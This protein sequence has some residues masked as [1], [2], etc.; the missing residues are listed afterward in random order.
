MISDAIFELSYTLSTGTT[1]FYCSAEQVKFSLPTLRSFVLNISFGFPVK[2][3]FLSVFIMK[4]SVM[5][6]INKILG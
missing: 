6:K 1:L 5:E 4:I 3:S 2:F